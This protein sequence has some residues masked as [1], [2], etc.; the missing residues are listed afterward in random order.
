MSVRTNLLLPKDVVEGI[1]RLAGPRGR[2]KYVADVLRERIRREARMA[3][4]TSAAGIWKD[5]PEFPTDESV[6][7]WVRKLRSEE[8]DPWSDEPP[9]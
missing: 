4:L 8:R 3:A 1:D 9:R 5:H 7:E 2:S 6:V